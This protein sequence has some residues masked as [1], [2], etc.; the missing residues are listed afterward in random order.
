M[1]D[2]IREVDEEYRRDRVVN[3]LTKYQVALI[4]LVVAIILGTAVY[5]I[6]LHYQ[7]QAAETANARYDAAAQLVR[8]G[9]GAEA[10]AA[11]DKLQGDGPA[12][13]AMLARLKAVETLAL[14][15]KAA[16]VRGYDAIAG[17]DSMEATLRDT[18][19]IRGAIL[20]VD[21][22][23][24]KDFELRYTPYATEGFAYRSTLREL[25]T[26]AAF[27]RNDTESAGRWLDQ[28]VI[29]PN[30]PSAL[31]S[32]AEAFLG[33]VA[34]GPVGTMPEAT[35]PALELHPTATPVAPPAA[36]TVATP[37][38]AVPATPAAPVSAPAAPTT[39]EASPAK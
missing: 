16:A 2:F 18:A 14:R 13:Y 23:D 17:D 36:S 27:K 33:L 10:Q 12:G 37:S 15:D 4:G 38:V 31:R 28:I 20:R 11:F 29:D 30:A 3:F 7:N 32:R 34:A 35:K 25:L 21:S 39:P 5:R 8:D 9:K 22:D 24:P 26:L 1:S 6:Y 19:L